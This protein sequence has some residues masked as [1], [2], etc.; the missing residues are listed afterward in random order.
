[1]N[2]F[3][4]EFNCCTKAKKKKK[5]SNKEM[6]S[7]LQGLELF[8]C[9]PVPV[10]V[11]SI[12]PFTYMQLSD[13]VNSRVFV[14]TVKVVQPFLSVWRNMNRKKEHNV[15]VE[16]LFHRCWV[17]PKKYFQ[18]LVEQWEVQKPVIAEIRHGYLSQRK[19][20]SRLDQSH[21]KLA[22][23]C[24]CFRQMIQWLAMSQANMETGLSPHPAFKRALVST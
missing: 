22:S 3:Q 13:S 5:K 19:N 17:I 8:T 14:F 24:V 6:K 7:H 11:S 1:M 23:K 10:P 12:S 2:S 16:E 4:K 20:P 15:E 21:Q 9:P 18:I